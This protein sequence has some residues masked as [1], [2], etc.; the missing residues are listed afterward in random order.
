MEHR[1]VSAFAGLD[2][3]RPLRV[4]DGVVAWAVEGERTTFALIEL[5]AG[6]E[7][8]EHRHDNEQLG[9]LI[10]G[11]MRFRI[12][13]EVRDVVP[14]DTWNIPGGVP[15]QVDV[16]PDGALVAECFTPTRSDWAE[17]ERLEG[18]PAPAWPS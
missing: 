17:K 18:H 4:W 9:V 5:E 1:T 11:S 6:R 7:V 16:G 10:A 2:D 15:H 12:G 8:P 14:G 3:L 13:D